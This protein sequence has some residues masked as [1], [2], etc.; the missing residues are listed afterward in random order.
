[1]FGK[2][3]KNMKYAVRYRWICEPMKPV[4]LNGDL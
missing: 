4:Q 3:A 1:M 2:L